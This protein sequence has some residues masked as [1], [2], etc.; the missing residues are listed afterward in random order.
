MILSDHV[1]PQKETRKGF[2]P[3]GPKKKK[4][5]NPPFLGGGRDPGLGKTSRQK[6]RQWVPSEGKQ[7]DLVPN[8]GGRSKTQRG[9]TSG[10]RR[11]KTT[12]LEKGRRKL[13]VHLCRDPT[14][15]GRGTG[16]KI[17]E[18]SP[19]QKGFSSVG[20][21]VARDGKENRYPKGGGKVFCHKNRRMEESLVAAFSGAPTFRKKGLEKKRGEKKGEAFV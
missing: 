14:E 19:P 20:R 15:K 18:G 1:G 17:T 9:K 5:K 12:S 7:R 13:K 6:G 4:K 16:K 3:K 10:I 8:R 11:T 21:G 2:D